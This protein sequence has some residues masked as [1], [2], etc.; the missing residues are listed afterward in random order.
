MGIKNV[1]AIVLLKIAVNRTSPKALRERLREEWQAYLDAFPD[2]LPKLRAA[3]GFLWSTFHQEKKIRLFFL[4]NAEVFCSTL[5]MHAVNKIDFPHVWSAW[6]ILLGI[7]GTTVLYWEPFATTQN[8]EY[9]SDEITYLGTSRKLPRGIICSITF[10]A[11]LAAM[12]ACAYSHLIVQGLV[13]HNVHGSPALTIVVVCIVFAC[14]P[15]GIYV[16]A[17]ME[18][19][20]CRRWLK[21]LEGLRV[22][23]EE[24]RYAEIRRILKLIGYA[25]VCMAGIAQLLTTLF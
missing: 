21:K 23:G 15:F 10:F 25:A 19:C 8:L 14:A 5:L 6:I 3:A 18:R 20:Q 16:L 9:I 13:K 12:Q 7:F 24:P 4:I 1:L 2:G 11:V 22:S 17:K